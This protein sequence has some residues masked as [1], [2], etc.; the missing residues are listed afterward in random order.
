MLSGGLQMGKN[1]LI[2]GDLA[3]TFGS[4]DLRLKTGAA[5]NRD[6]THNRS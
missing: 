1:S 2:L 5:L 3:K 4:K 6:W